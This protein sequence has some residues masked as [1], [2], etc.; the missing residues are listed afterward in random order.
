MVLG[1]QLEITLQV[2]FV[3]ILITHEGIRAG[4]I[5]GPIILRISMLGLSVLVRE[6]IHDVST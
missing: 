2:K 6:S 1:K 3:S 4:T 5:L